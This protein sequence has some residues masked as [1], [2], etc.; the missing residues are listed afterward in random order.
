MCPV[1][2]VFYALTHRMVSHGTRIFLGM[3]LRLSPVF[4]IHFALKIRRY[5]RNLGNGARSVS[6]DRDPEMNHGI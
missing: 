5:Y 2:T 1:I 6:V 4:Q 3:C